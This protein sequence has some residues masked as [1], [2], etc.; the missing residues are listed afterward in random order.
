MKT[1]G[2]Q[3]SGGVGDRRVL[4]IFENSPDPRITLSS[5][6]TLYPA[7]ALVRFLRASLPMK[8]LSWKLKNTEEGTRRVKD[9]KQRRTQQ[10]MSCLHR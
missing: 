3:Q 2:M 6:L 4:D 5:Y 7:S 9:Q 8:A 10:T 1:R